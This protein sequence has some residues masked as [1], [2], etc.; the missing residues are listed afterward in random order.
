MAL[1]AL[2]GCSR[3][4]APDAAMNI[5]ENA[6]TPTPT[7]IDAGAVLPDLDGAS[8]DAANLDAGKKEGGPVVI[9]TVNI[10]HSARP[11]PTYHVVD[12]LPGPSRY[13]SAP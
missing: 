11:K 1:A 3:N 2:S 7:P 12:E 13:R 9:P 4:A 6:P 8:V 10:Q 5:E